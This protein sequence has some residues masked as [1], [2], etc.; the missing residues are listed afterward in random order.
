LEKPSGEDGGWEKIYTLLQKGT[1]VVLRVDMRYLPYLYGGKYGPK[2]MSFGFHLVCLAGMNAEKQTAYVTDT[3]H[4]ALQEI[5][6]SDLHKARFSDTDVYPP[7]GQFYWTDKANP[8]WKPDWERIAEESLRETKQAMT[9]VLSEGGT[10][11][12]LDGLSRYPSALASLDERVPSYLLAPVLSFHYGCI[13]TNGTGGSAFRKMY[14]S[15]LEEEG[16]KSGNPGLLAAAGKLE[17]AV[18]VWSEL[19]S[20]MEE[21]SRNKSALKNKEERKKALDALSVMADVLYQREKEF[22]ESIE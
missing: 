1:P 17:P 4:P 18:A 14:H 2:Y 13:E 15:F 12:G 16:R 3:E 9:E 21:L 19:A 22:Y 8:D 7:E 20:G 11:L 5:K 10:L 6:L